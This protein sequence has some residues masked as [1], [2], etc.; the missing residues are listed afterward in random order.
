MKNASSAGLSL[1]YTHWT[2]GEAEA[3][4]EMARSHCA[5]FGKQVQIA[6]SMQPGPMPDKVLVTYNCV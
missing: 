4:M 3:A 1:Q 6:G 5:Y 2:T